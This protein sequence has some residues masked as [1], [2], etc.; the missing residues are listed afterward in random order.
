MQNFVESLHARGSERCE[1]GQRRRASGMVH[2]GQSFQAFGIPFK[3]QSKSVIVTR[4]LNQVLQE[5]PE[6]P[7]N[8]PDLRLETFSDRSVMDSLS[9]LWRSRP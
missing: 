6:C 3:D 8:L 2:P 4:W 5:G 9:M 1:E 7:T